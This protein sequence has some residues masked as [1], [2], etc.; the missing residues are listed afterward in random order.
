M[1]GRTHDRLF[2]ACGIAFVALELIGVA[3]GGKSHHLT[4]SSS[5]TQIAQAL[6]KP[7]GTLSWVGGYM[8]LLSFGFFLAFAVWACSKLGGGLVG[9][10]ARAAGTSY[11]TLSVASLAVVDAISYR[12]G[13]GLSV[14]LGRT[15]VSVNEALYVGSWFLIAFFLLAAGAGALG[16]ARRGLGW[17]AIGI[18]LFTLLATAASINGIGQFGILLFFA[19]VVYASV[20][21]ARGARVATGA[22]VVA[23]HA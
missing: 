8:E 5:A 3:I 17:S 13:H 21:L 9:Q 2:A 6:S 1:N 12:A 20:S 7:A 23:G 19:W 14:Q 11:A 4:V 15:L 10:I 22:A 16:A 18:A